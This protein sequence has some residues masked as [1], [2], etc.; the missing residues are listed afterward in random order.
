MKVATGLAEIEDLSTN[1]SRLPPS[2]TAFME[3][4]ITLEKSPNF[5]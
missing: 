3:E 1:V 2:E 4:E 5:Y